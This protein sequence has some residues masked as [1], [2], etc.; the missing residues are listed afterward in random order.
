MFRILGPLEASAGDV[1]ADLGSPK[2]RTVLAVLLLHH[3]EVVPVDRLVE[4]V[5]GDRPPRTAEHSIQ[6]YVGELRRAFERSGL[7]ATIET[8]RPGYLLAFDGEHLDAERFETL[9]R[10]GERRL[11]DGETEEG[12]ATLE[13]ALEVWTGRPLP[14]FTY[15]EFA[16]PAIRRLERLHAEAVTAH[17]E[18]CLALGRP[19]E[20]LEPLRALAAADPLDD[21]VCRLLAA[22]LYAEGRHAE[23]LRVCE[24]HR[25]ALADELG[26]SPSPGLVDL[27]TS[28]LRHDPRLPAMGPLAGPATHPGPYKGLRAFD[29]QDAADFYGRERLVGR[30]LDDLTAGVRFLALV[31]P[32]GCGKSS[33]VRAGLVPALR[34]GRVP[35][36]GAWRVEVVVPDHEPIAQL[37]RLAGVVPAGDRPVLVVDQLEQLFSTCDETDQRRFLSRL[38]QMS[39]AGTAVI[40]TLRADFYDRPL[41]HSAFAEAFSAGV[42]DVI[43]MTPAELEAAAAKPAIS[44]GAT[45]EP[46]LLAELVAT[47][48]DRPGSLPLFQYVLGELW[49]RRRGSVL[50]LD[51]YRGLGGL[52]GAVGRQADAIYGGLDPA[53]REAARQVFLRLASGEG[54]PPVRR[55]VPLAELVRMETDP[56]A[57]DAVLE[58][59]GE[60]RLLTFDRDPSTGAAT[61]E[62]AHEILLVAWERLASWIGETRGDLARREA[63]DRAV[64]EWEGSGRDPDYLPT[65][66]RLDELERWAGSTELALTPEE[67]GF[68][69]GAR[70]L[71]EERREEE[72]RR[73]EERRQLARRSRRRLWGLVASVVVLVAIGTY[74]GLS[75]LL[76]PGPPDVAVLVDGDVDSGGWAGLMAEGARRA[77]AETGLDIRMVV[78]DANDPER[79]VKVLNDLAAQG[80]GL[81]VYA[82]APIFLGEVELGETSI[83]VLDRLTEVEGAADQTFAEQE[84]SFLVGVVAARTTTTGKVGFIGGV[85]LPEPIWRFHAGFEAGVQ[86]ADPTVEVIPLYL[87]PCPDSSGFSAA[88]LG[89]VGAEA[90]FAEGVDVVYHAAGASGFGVIVAADHWSTVE[91]R[92]R[93]VIGVDSD[94]YAELGD[95]AR[96]AEAQPEL[97]APAEVYRAMQAHVLTSM[98]KRVDQAV[99]ASILD[100]ASGRLQAG[101]HVLDL[102]AGGLDYSRS[103]GFVDH[104]VPELEEWRRRIVAGE[105]HVPTIPSDRDLATWVCDF[106]PTEL[107]GVVRDAG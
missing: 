44:R 89:A 97:Y 49:E 52:A 2:A 16:Q 37:E 102:A 42:V 48:V 95:L 79:V 6:V 7:E 21:R 14:E 24:S 64:A 58:G 92:W 43:P 100:W 30:L 59:F 78:A 10:E 33:V 41:G 22:A 94:Q 67:T 101:T 85:D 57:L 72:G 65:G 103:G 11:H 81:I 60:A 83:V 4:A 70:R 38:L 75:W 86:A 66:S 99:Y 12:L 23:A 73:L 91:G 31:G 61:V 69:S 29:E 39:V 25:T 5:W 3:D 34:S 62:V 26:L 105:I 50:R 8:R 28:I 19:S 96:A 47:A 107:Q 15:D 13:R 32:S 71:E 36:S 93:W 56:R 45:I 17:A 82:S 18:A 98:E 68:V 35:G 9:A 54:D 53:G 55:R 51:D 27:E 46:D 1:Q 104:L 80:T 40:A 74:S 90:L 106:V 87:S 63:L 20:A 84:G 77:A 88:P 76:R